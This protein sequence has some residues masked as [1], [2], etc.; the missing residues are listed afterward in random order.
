MGTNNGDTK[1]SVGVQLVINEEIEGNLQVD[2]DLIVLGNFNGSVSTT[3]LTLPGYLTVSGLSSLGAV[4]TTGLL[5]TP[6]IEIT[7]SGGRMIVDS[8]TGNSIFLHS[9]ANPT[10]ESD[11][12]GSFFTEGGA[13]VSDDLYVGGT[14]YGTIQGQQTLD[15]V[16]IALDVAETIGSLI[17]F[18]V[19]SN[20]PDATGTT[21]NINALGQASMQYTNDI[22]DFGIIGISGSGTS[23][24]NS[25]FITGRP[26]NFYD[27][28]ASTSISTGSAVFAGGVGVGGDL[29]VGGTIHG[30]VSG[31]IT[32][33][34][35]SLS[36]TLGV[37][38]TSTLGVLNAAAVSGTSGS[39]ST[40]LSV[41]GTSTLGV[42]NASFITAQQSGSWVAI[43]P[44]STADVF[45][46]FGA[47][48]ASGSL[49]NLHFTTP[50]ATLEFMQLHSTGLVSIPGTLSVGGGVSVGALNVSST[51]YN[52]INTAGG[53]YASGSIYTASQ[54]NSSLTNDSGNSTDS[55]ASIFVQ[56]GASVE[57]TVSA[58]SFRSGSNPTF[59][60]QE[61]TFTLALGYAP[62]PF[63]DQNACSFCRIGNIVTYTVNFTG[64]WSG[65]N[66]NNI[67]LIGFPFNFNP[68]FTLTYGPIVVTTVD[69]GGYNLYG[70]GG[71]G[72]TTMYF[73]NGIPGGYSTPWLYNTSGGY[74][75][76][77]NTFTV[78]LI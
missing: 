2:G 40:T 67:Q 4:T 34:N 19:T 20:A 41:T 7:G 23:P 71:P 44:Q 25:F 8:T 53:V 36:G 54:F 29:W 30:S 76:I 14:I 46:E 27:T 47:S 6:N 72:T 57:K 62:S 78:L 49:A 66:T 10:N 26:I 17:A 3:N 56:G 65:S 31:T 45:F 48:P 55:G 75:E 51:A 70:C 60:Y 9:T 24:A 42:V 61:G 32:T 38:G 59:G 58:A 16:T 52:S 37:T 50:S 35:L 1:S 39:F 15:A 11:T 21:T 13:V 68:S 28:T 63:I 22:G 33:P 12:G 74:I 64:G 43:D 77:T 69:G 18:K 73:V 5:K